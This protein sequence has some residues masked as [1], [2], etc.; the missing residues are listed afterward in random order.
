MFSAILR[1]SNLKTIYLLVNILDECDSN[2]HRFIDWIIKDTSTHL[3]KTKW[4]L[5]SRHTT[6]IEETFRQGGQRQKLNLNLNNHI[7]ITI[8]IFIEHKVM[9]LATKKEYNCELREKIEIQ[10]KEKA[11]SI[12]F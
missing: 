10:L 2:S 5:S 1:D 7:S 3:F 8:N 6:K 12:F 4:L 9:N 11:E